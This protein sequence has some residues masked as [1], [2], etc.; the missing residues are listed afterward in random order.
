[1]FDAGDGCH[2]GLGNTR[3][4]DSPYSLWRYA[5]SRSL[6][7]RSKKGCLVTSLIFSPHI[8]AFVMTSSTQT[9][10]HKIAAIT[11]VFRNFKKSIFNKLDQKSHGKTAPFSAS[12]SS[13]FT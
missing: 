4:A 9:A 12:A 8:Q 10:W 13:C 3:A 11:V 2:G 1:M 7:M 5:V 6:R